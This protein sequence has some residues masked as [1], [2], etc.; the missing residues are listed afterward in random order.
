MGT[1]SKAKPPQAGSR[2]SPNSP[3]STPT[4]STPT[5]DQNHLPY[6]KDLTGSEDAVQETWLRY[7]ASPTQ[8]TS[9]KAFLSAVVTR[10]SIDVLRLARVWRE[11]YV[12]QWFPEPLLTDPLRGSGAVGRA[13]GFGIDGS[14]VASRAAQPARA[15][16]LRAAGRVRIR[17]PRGRVGRRQVGGG[18]PPARGAGAAPHGRGTPPLRSRPPGTRG[19][20][21]AVLRRPPRWRHR[22]S[23]GAARC[24]RPD[25]RGWGRQGSC[26]S[27]KRD[28]CRQRGPRTCV[29]LAGARPHRRK[30]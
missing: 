7:E 11:A 23:E 10:V 27:Q 2:P 19:A 16:G 20:G 9:T 28:R 15:G 22:G 8:P 17:L 5:Y 30:N 1:S 4:E 12:G 3:S 25:G 26:T 29:D 13:G 18:L 24:R 6:T 21:S 14:P